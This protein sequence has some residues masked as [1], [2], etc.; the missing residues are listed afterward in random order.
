VVTNE[1]GLGIGPDNPLARL[2]RDVLGN[3]NRVLAACAD[4]V[5]LMTAGLPLR[6]K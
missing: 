4:E 5:Y 2:Y 3:A 1:V 6:L